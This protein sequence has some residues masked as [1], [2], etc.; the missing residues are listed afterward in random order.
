[1]ARN[2][3]QLSDRK[4]A[5]SPSFQFSIRS[6]FMITAL[7]ALAILFLLE[8]NQRFGPVATAVSIITFLSIFAH[9]AGAALGSRLRSSKDAAKASDEETDNEEP[10]GAVLQ[11]LEAQSTDFA[12][13]TQLSHQKP[14]N[15]KPI[16]WAVGSGAAI[17]SILAS[18]VLTWFMWDDLAIVNVLFGAVSAAVIG[19]LFGYLLGSLYQVVRDALAEAQE[20]T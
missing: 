19:G 16:Y 17:A 4:Q 11:P 8:V 1:M 7:I 6:I 12:P 15:N 18:I 9:V 13:V 10:Q 3:R 2:L 14:L 20:K 5:I